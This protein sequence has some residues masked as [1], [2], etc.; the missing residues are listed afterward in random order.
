[1][2]IIMLSL[3]LVLC[4]F[5]CSKKDAEINL[6]VIELIPNSPK[7][8]NVGGTDWT[9]TETL[10]ADGKPIITAKSTWKVTQ[11]DISSSAVPSWAKVGA[12]YTMTMDMSDPPGR[13]GHKVTCYFR[14][15][16]ASYTLKYDS[17]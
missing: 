12:D 7:L 13:K 10:G 17:N 4:A 15:K 9:I 2:K 14:N 6:G 11:E 1:M 5:G 8:L 3:V 16:L